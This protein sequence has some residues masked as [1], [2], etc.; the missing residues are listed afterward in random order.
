V[1]HQL[2]AIGYIMMS[3]CEDEETQKRGVVAVIYYVGQLAGEFN[4]QLNKRLAKFPKFLPYRLS[5]YHI[6]FDDPRLRAWKPL[7]MLLMGR[8][9]RV[10]LRIHDGESIAG[11]PKHHY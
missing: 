4:H 10:R 6:C 7:A 9:L 1:F 8:S 3:A 11:M 2:K 5:G